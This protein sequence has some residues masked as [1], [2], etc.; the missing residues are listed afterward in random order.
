MRNR[1]NQ[2]LEPT[3]NKSIKNFPIKYII[4]KQKIHSPIFNAL[5]QGVF[6]QVGKLNVDGISSES[7]IEVVSNS[8]AE[9]ILIDLI[10]VI[11]IF[12]LVVRE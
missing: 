6:I 12:Q 10:H 1:K 7:A 8:F 9:V 3:L 5:Y 4:G 11:K 2:F